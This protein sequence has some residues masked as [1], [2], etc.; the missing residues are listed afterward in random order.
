MRLNDTHDSIDPNS[1]LSSQQPTSHDPF[2]R[3]KIWVPITVG[4]GCITIYFIKKSVHYMRQNESLK[5]IAS[6]AASVLCG[7]GSIASG[8]GMLKKNDETPLFLP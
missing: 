1:P 3:F 7:F 6:I 5:A 2:I 4:L 8:V